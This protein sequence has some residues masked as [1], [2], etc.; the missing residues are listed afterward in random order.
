LNYI[1][2]D[3]SE[4]HDMVDN[5]NEE[6][7]NAEQHVIN[8]NDEENITENNM[9]TEEIDNTT[10]D[11]TEE[12]TS[13]SVERPRRENIGAGIERLEMS[14]DSSKSYSSTKNKGQQFTMM[15]KDEQFSRQGKSFLSVAA[16]ILFT[17]VTEHAQMLAKAGIKK[18]GD[19][20]VA[21]MLSEY[22]QPGKSVFGSIDPSNITTEE[23]KR[24]L[25]AV[26]LIKKK[27]CGKIKGR[28]CANGSKQKRYL[29]H[30]ETISSPTVSLEAI[31]G[32]LL[33]D[34]KENRNVAIFDVPGA[35]LQA[36]MPKDK[37][38]LMKF[39]DE[40][41]DIMCEVNP[42]YKKYMI[43]ENGKR[44]L[45]IRILR[46]IYGCIES[47][48]LWYELY[49][50][51][52]K[53][54]GF[55]LNPYDRCVANKMIN[56]KQ[57]TIAW[58]VDNN[59]I[60]HEDPSVVMSI[61]EKVKQ[62]FRDLVISRGEEHN[63]LGMRIIMDRKNKRVIINMKDQIKEAIEMFGEDVDA[64]VSSP[65]N[66][67]LFNTYDDSKELNEEKSKIFHSVVAKI[68]FIMK[69]A[70]PDVETTISYLMTQVSKSN[71]EDW[72]KLKRCLGFMKGTI[73]DKRIIGADS[74]SDLH[75]WVDASHAIH[76]DMRGHTGGTMSMGTGTLH[77]R[78]G[79]QKLNT[80]STTE[81]E[82]VGVSEYLPYNIWQVNFFKEQGYDIRNN[83]IYQDNESAIKMEQNGP[84]SCTGNS[85]HIDIKYFWVKDRINGK[86]PKMLAIFGI[87]YFH[88]SL[89]IMVCNIPQLIMVFLLNNMMMVPT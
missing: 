82:L 4:N 5:E 64:G 60:L 89:P 53:G 41:V 26:N 35:Y 74:L 76:G 56:G 80:R 86:G 18:F 25:E 14:M 77:C 69:R 50:K 10:N 6:N 87:H 83:I 73:D 3:E 15:T 28:T 27:R 81:S 33:I 34:S 65:A 7:D 39:R 9:D 72:K 62:H 36:E 71:V 66:K 43:E 70:R 57:C 30:G 47:A 75:V 51:I 31:I 19:K 24:A 58:Y 78:S 2:E 11:E 49:V 61:L 17:Q 54:M 12:T 48:L 32:T 22:K 85:R 46:A 63:L 42:E 88:H 20:V 1:T 40:F 23:C 55:V 29:K 84:N 16:N 44:V 52:L 45:Y 38:L 79:K 8:D 67:N 37:K 21:A 13:Y 68:L 59:K